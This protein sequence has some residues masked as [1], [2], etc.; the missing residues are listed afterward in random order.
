MFQLSMIQTVQP[1]L[2]LSLMLMVRRDILL[3]QK[4]SR[5]VIRLNLEKM[6]RLSQV[7]IY[8]LKRFHWA[9]ISII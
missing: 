8:H 4:G 7:I 9:L 2:L 6:Q 3:L 1:I 5:L